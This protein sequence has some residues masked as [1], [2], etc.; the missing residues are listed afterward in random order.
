MNIYLIRHGQ[1]EMNLGG[2][3]QYTATPLSKSGVEEAQSLAER[4]KE[5]A[6]DVIYSSPFVRAKQTAEHIAA[7]TGKKVLVLDALQ[8]LRRPSEMEGKKDDDLIVKEIKRGMRENYANKEW[9]YS[10]EENFWDLK[11]RIEQLMQ[12]L[13]QEQAEHILLVTHGVVIK[14]FLALCVLRDKL[15]PELF[16]SFQDTLYLSTAG[17]TQCHYSQQRDWMVLRMNDTAHLEEI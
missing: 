6:I 10:D 2:V 11:Q 14:M 17:I 15:T 4:L 12:L 16:L 5:A 3:Y 1:S 7:P 13:Q 9:H 8:E